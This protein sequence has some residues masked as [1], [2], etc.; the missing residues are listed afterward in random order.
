MRP[1]TFLHGDAGPPSKSI[2]PSP[3]L[4]SRLLADR[5]QEGGPALL[6]E[7]RPE[8]IFANGIAFLV[9]DMHSLILRRIFFLVPYGSTLR[10]LATRSYPITTYSA[11][12]LPEDRSAVRTTFANFTTT[13]PTWSNKM[14]AQPT[15]SNMLVSLQDGVA[16][17]TF[18]NEASGN[19]LSIA[20]L[21]VS[22]TLRQSITI[23]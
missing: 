5:L 20:Q 3:A 2:P 4:S 19:P 8:Q 17:L 9:L 1:A 18:N 11:L 21:K 10:H 7:I 15:L 13:S 23:S 14:A 6:L 22:N 16:T 12:A